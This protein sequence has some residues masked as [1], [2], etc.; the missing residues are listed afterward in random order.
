VTRTPRAFVPAQLRACVAE[1]LFDAAVVP[2]GVDNM[3]DA[4]TSDVAGFCRSGL[5]ARPAFARRLGPFPLTPD[6]VRALPFVGPVRAYGDRIVTII[7][8]GPFP[9]ERRWIAHEAQTIGA[10]LELVSRSDHVVFG[11]VL[12][13][14]RFLGSGALVPVV[15]W[16][17]R[18]Q[19]A[20]SCSRCPRR[21]SASSR[22]NSSPQM[23]RIVST[24]Q[25]PSMSERRYAARALSF[26]KCKPSTVN[27]GRDVAAEEGASPSFSQTRSA[28]AYLIAQMSRTFWPSS[29]AARRRSRPTG[30]SASPNA[31]PGAGS[32]ENSATNRPSLVNSTISLV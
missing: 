8:D 27:I 30:S 11:P 4:W 5:L 23:S 14:R 9:R 20:P 1:D 6:R 25:W 21:P 26:S 28:P 32:T 24:V 17:V 15:G 19:M 29:T 3:S 12:A 18:E 13:A 16:E 10:A 7:D 22:S 2:G 31:E